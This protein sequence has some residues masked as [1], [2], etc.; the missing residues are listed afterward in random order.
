VVLIAKG[1]AG[2]DCRSI[3]KGFLAK[4]R[5]ARAMEC[6]PAIGQAAKGDGEFPGKDQKGRGRGRIS[7]SRRRAVG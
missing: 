5:T 4:S 7:G 3:L 2:K 6:F 1:R